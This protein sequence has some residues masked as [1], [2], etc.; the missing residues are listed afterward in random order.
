M[1]YKTELIKAMKEL[2]KDDRVRFI[3]YNTT[4]GPRM[5][6]TLD[7]ISKSKCI[8]MPVAENL[9]MGIAMG[10]SLAGYRPV[11]CIERSDFLLVCADAIVNHL[12]KLPQLSGGQFSFPVI[13]RVCVG[14]NSPL[15]PGS[16]HLQDYTDAFA[17]MT[18]SLAISKL[19]HPDDIVATYRQAHIFDEP[20]MIV[21]YKGLYKSERG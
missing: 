10:M 2:S 20:C 11:V 19:L 8:E 18:H 5:N 4:C 17:N 9:I 7:G 16:Q 14:S 13:I 3:G 21:E 6:K 15:D 12:D 1:I